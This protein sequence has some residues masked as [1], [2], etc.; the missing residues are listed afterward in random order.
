MPER[1]FRSTSAYAARSRGATA[2]IERATF[3]T[4]SVGDHRFGVPVECV[5]RV[6]RDNADSASACL[7][8][9]VVHYRGVAVPVVSLA[10]YLGLAGNQVNRLERGRTPAMAGGAAAA[11]RILIINLPSGWVAIAVDAVHDVATIDAALITAAHH[12]SGDAG[13]D[14]H[15]GALLPGVRGMFV[16]KDQRT[17]VLDVGH[18]LGFRFPHDASCT[19]LPA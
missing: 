17:L 2:A 14:S 1:T 10:P 12:G 4:F 11:A 15:P 9:P 7:A 18:T 6:L 5:E 16:R 19:S 3:V 8:A 13:Q